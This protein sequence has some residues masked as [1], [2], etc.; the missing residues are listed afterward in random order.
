[1]ASLAH[2]INLGEGNDSA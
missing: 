2:L 1:M